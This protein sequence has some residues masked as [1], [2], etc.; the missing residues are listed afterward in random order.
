MTFA[1]LKE[2]HDSLKTKVDFYEQEND[3][4]KKIIKM[5]NKEKFG[6]KSEVYQEENLQQVFNEIE[7]E[8]KDAQLPML[9]ETITY[10]RKKGRGKK[11]PFPEN[12]PREDKI[13][14]IPELNMKSIQ[15]DIFSVCHKMPQ[16]TILRN[17]KKIIQ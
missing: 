16:N 10:T 3:A 1:E 12:L 11:K 8:G 15:T 17:K 4:L 2:K 9:Q 13:I 5:Y 14:D 6:S 7:T